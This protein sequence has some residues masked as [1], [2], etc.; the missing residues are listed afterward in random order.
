[1]RA[2]K[3]LALAGA[4]ACA[5]MPLMAGPASADAS[6]PAYLERTQ[7]LTSTPTSANASCT[8]R[9]IYLAAGYYQPVEVF[10]G[11]IASEPGFQV[12][13]SDT[14]SWSTCLNGLDNGRYVIDDAMGNGTIGLIL[15]ASS[16]LNYHVYQ[17]GTYT[18]GI[19][20]HHT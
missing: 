4:L 15:N 19:V 1:M 11:A 8:S 18:W 9:D 13:I 12:P 14:Y 2:F 6:P 3:K 17:S 20:L 5:A 7:Y 16:G 10:G